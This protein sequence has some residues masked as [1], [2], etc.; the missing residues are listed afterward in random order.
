M[1]ILDDIKIDVK[2]FF[3]T[4][5]SDIEKSLFFFMYQVSI[6]NQSDKT[7]QLINRHWNISDANGNTQV[8]KGEGVIGEKPIKVEKINL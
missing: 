4:N 3:L 2:S 5:K 6:S 1:D 8:I 7:I